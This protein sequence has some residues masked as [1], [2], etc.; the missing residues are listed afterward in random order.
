M[1]L[2]SLLILFVLISWAPVRAQEQNTA[3]PCPKIEFVGPAELVRPGD[4]IVFMLKI[5]RPDREKLSYKW[6]TSYG[7]I[8]DGQGTPSIT[9]KTNPLDDGFNA[10]A[11]VEIEGLPAGCPATASETVGVSDGIA[12]HPFL[13]DEY[14]GL[15][16]REE[17]SPLENAVLTLKR[18]PDQKLL[19][20]LYRK[21]GASVAAA[22]KH[23]V[24]ISRYLESRGVSKKKFDFVYAELDAHRTK[25]RLVPEGAA[26]P[27]LD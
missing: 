16:F 23:A 7:T 4:R 15:S 26:M 13:V 3:P 6:Y 18:E 21:K 25:I 1:K 9:V 2:V 17:K 22:K 5:D 24:N 10:T 14:E 27:V 20:V 8:V 19:F 11:T 12:G